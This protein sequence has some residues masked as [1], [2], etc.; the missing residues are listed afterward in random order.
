ML[1]PSRKF[2][3][4]T[5]PSDQCTDKLKIRNG[6]GGFCVY[7]RLSTTILFDLQRGER[8]M[9]SSCVPYIQSRPKCSRMSNLANDLYATQNSSIRSDTRRLLNFLNLILFYFKFSSDREIFNANSQS[10]FQLHQS[11]QTTQKYGKDI[12]QKKKQTK[13][14]RIVVLPGHVE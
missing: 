11:I 10:Q 2:P 7:L 3:V 13:T 4:N 5:S 9:M 1:W 8:P 6:Q 12:L 14:T